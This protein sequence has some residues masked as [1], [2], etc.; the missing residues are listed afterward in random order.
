MSN[1]SVIKD[2]CGCSS[3]AMSCPIGAISMQENEEG[4]LYPVIDEKKCT[5]CGLCLK[6]CPIHTIK[7]YNDSTPACYAVMASDDLRERSSSGAVFP[8]VANYFLKKG[9]YV[10]GAVWDSDGSVKHIVSNSFDDIERM[11]GSK[12][13]QSAMGSCYK[14]VKKLLDKDIEVLFTG[15]PCQIAGLKAYLKKGYKNLFTVEIICH[16]TPSPK[17]FKKYLNEQLA[18]DEKFIETNFRDKIKGWNPSLTISTTTN[19]RKISYSAEQDSFMN[20]FLK[21]LCLRD[22]CSSC[23][24]NRIPRQADLT[25]GDF[26]G[27]DKY[28]KRYNDKKGTSVLLVNTFKGKSL[29][30]EIQKEFKLFKKVPLKYAIKGNPNLITSSKVTSRRIEF[31]K[32][33]KSDKLANIVKSLSTDKCDYLIVNFWDSYFNYGALLMAYAMQE[34]IKGFGFEVKLLDTGERTQKRA[35]R[36]TFGDNFSKKYLATTSVLKFNKA[37]ELTKDI[38]GVIVGSDQVLRLE[39]MGNEFNKYLLNFVSANCRKLAISSSFGIDESEFVNYKKY[40]SKMHNLMKKALSSFDYLSCREIS[41]KNIYKNVFNL[42]SDMILDPVFLI[43]KES[44][45][46]ILKEADIDYSGKIVN[47]VL[48]EKEEYKSIYSDLEK[49]KSAKMV[50][51]YEKDSCPSVANWLNAIK[52]CKLF[53]TDSFHGVCFALIFNKPFICIKNKDR[54]SARFDSLIETFGIKESFI[55]SIKEYSKEKNIDLDYDKVNKKIEA[56]KQRCISRIEEVLKNNYSNNPNKKSHNFN[57][58]LG[59]KYYLLY[60]KYYYNS[61]LS[62]YRR[63]NTNKYYDRSIAYK[64]QKEWGIY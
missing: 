52:T 39:Y 32:R 5:N 8:V 33:I 26:W 19:V 46:C 63:K 29:I 64:H 21:N 24:F 55:S 60:L 28:N 11:R 15:T 34:L 59:I 6:S 25:I 47:Y 36:N 53:I 7:Y 1:I 12:Y 40:S 49:S 18:S 31:F 10:A 27:I 2:C 14:E 58:K 13:L 37:K 50:K 54:G 38:K 3:C 51:L 42:D 62:K 56:E 48:D 57:K 41:G 23:K 9:A 45:E 17:V 35:Y 44:F 61:F 22:S 16:G 30:K 4:F 43:P 20:A